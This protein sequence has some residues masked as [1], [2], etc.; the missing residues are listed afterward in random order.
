MTAQSRI[1]AF[2][3]SGNGNN[4]TAFGGNR[5]AHLPFPAYSSSVPVSTIPQ[6]GASDTF[7]L[8]LGGN[9][10][11]SFNY[12]FPFDTDTDATLEFYL[13]PSSVGAEQDL[14]WTTTN[15]G[16]TNRFNIGIGA[17]GSFFLDYRDSSG[18]IDSVTGTNLGVITPNAWN[19]VVIVKSG[20]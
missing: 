15:G 17:G 14:F 8:S 6:T 3:S 9:D 11:V 7:S 16:D 4:G 1:L 12:A 20:D 2:D 5:L 13:D 18:A 19:F 10:G